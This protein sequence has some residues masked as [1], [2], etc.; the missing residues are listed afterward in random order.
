MG[1]DVG[2]GDDAAGD[3]EEDD[4]GEGQENPALGVAEEVVGADMTGGKKGLSLSMETVQG[5]PAWSMTKV[6][7]F[8]STTSKGPE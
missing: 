1:N 5:L 4:D 6:L 2:C 3:T 7:S 8:L